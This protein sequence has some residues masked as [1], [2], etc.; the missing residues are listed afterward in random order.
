MTLP[1]T[2][3]IIEKRRTFHLTARTKSLDHA[4][5][6][7]VSRALRDN[8]APLQR[9]AD[10]LHH[11]YAAHSGAVRLLKPDPRV[12]RTLT[13]LRIDGMFALAE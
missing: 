11:A 2:V 1:V 3:F 8:L 9:T 7:A 12:R 10:E 6:E 4:L 5:E 13:M